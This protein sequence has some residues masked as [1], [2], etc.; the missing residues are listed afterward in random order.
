MFIIA[1][2]IFLDILLIIQDWECL[3]FF[4][5]LTRISDL[6]YSFMA[7][8]S[9]GFTDSHAMECHSWCSSPPVPLNAVAGSTSELPMH[10]GGDRSGQ[11]SSDTSHCALEAGRVQAAP[12][13]G[14]VSAMGAGWMQ[15]VAPWLASCGVPRLPY[16]SRGQGGW[17]RKREVLWRLQQ[18]GWVSPVPLMGFSVGLC[19][20]LVL[21]FRFSLLLLLPLFLP[22]SSQPGFCLP[23]QPR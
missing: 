20:G 17:K 6:F 18:R 11:G 13:A 5:D 1:P 7:F 21:Y 23:G 15:H 22:V 9:C 4:P 12:G 19:F 2:F 10:W 14:G 3:H 8:L 16:M